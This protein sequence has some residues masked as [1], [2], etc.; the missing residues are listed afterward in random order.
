MCEV[1]EGKEGEASIAELSPW[2]AIWGCLKVAVFEG[3][4]FPL[5]LVVH[6]YI[7]CQWRLVPISSCFHHKCHKMKSHPLTIQLESPRCSPRQGLLCL[8]G[9]SHLFISF[10]RE[11]ELMLFGTDKGNNAAN[12]YSSALTP[13]GLSLALSMAGIRAGCFS[14][15]VHSSNGAHSP[16]I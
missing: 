11:G 10:P 2:L 5:V 7:L 13:A 16:S 4:S 14:S 3:T 8:S 15:S 9:I 12:I 1:S 6:W